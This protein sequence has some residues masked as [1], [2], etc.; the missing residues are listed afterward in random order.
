MAV[1]QT[2]RQWLCIAQY[3]HLCSKFRT[4]E[5]AAGQPIKT[6]GFTDVGFVTLKGTLHGE[7]SQ[8]DYIH[9][10]LGGENGTI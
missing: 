1:W 2:A 9:T 8:L 3:S 7:F 6:S 4:P 10:C 5:P